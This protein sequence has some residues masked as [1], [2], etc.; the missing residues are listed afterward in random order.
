MFNCRSNIDN[1]HSTVGGDMEKRFIL[2]MIVAATVNFTSVTVIAAID[3]GTAAYNAGDYAK[4][5]V[6]Y[7]K[8]AVQGNTAAQLKL[9]SMYHLGVG[10]VQN[11][12]EAMKWYLKAAEGGLAEAQYRVATLYGDGKG[13][14]PQDHAEEFIW[15]RKAADQGVPDAQ[16]NVGALYARGVGVTQDYAE[17]A[18]WYRKAAELGLAEA[19]FNLAVMYGK[20]QGG[21]Q[22]SSEEEKW[23]RRAA[24]QGYPDAQFNMGILYARGDGVPKDYTLAYMWFDLAAAKGN[25]RARRYRDTAAS[26]LTLAEIA[27]AR[28][29]VSEWKPKKE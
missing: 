11:Y 13:G 16:L 29:M 4:A 25:D 10:V 2:A 28:R 24:D 18:K 3:E 14:I 27:E 9:G 5:F 17:A 22:D 1:Q 20:G 6:E 8:M 26:Q 7:K 23:Y 15:Y 12:P 21:L 19:K